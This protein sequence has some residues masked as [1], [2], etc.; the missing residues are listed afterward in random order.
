MVSYL[1]V[2]GAFGAALFLVIA[3]LATASWLNPMP[4]EPAAMMSA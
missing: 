3:G 4:E 1:A 2:L